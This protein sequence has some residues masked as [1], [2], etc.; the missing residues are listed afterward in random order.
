MFD[1]EALKES[2]AGEYELRGDSLISDN[3]RI[4]LQA[5]TRFRPKRG[6]SKRYIMLTKFDDIELD[7]SQ[8]ISGLYPEQKNAFT[9]DIE[10]TY[11]KLNITSP[12]RVKIEPYI[13]TPTLQYSGGNHE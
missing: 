10:R 9:F 12:N 2:V 8:Y 13:K 5:C 7:R 3:R 11:F 4:E 1:S 6:Q